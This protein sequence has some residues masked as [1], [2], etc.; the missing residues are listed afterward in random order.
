MSTK[1]N[2]AAARTI[3]KIGRIILLSYSFSQISEFG[4]SGSQTLDS[5][6]LS[7]MEQSS[8]QF[9]LFSDSAQTPSPHFAD[10]DSRDV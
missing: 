3:I 9:R 10:S 2:M 1:I 7:F 4:Q 8:A 5:Q 6:K